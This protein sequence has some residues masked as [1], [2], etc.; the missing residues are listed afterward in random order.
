MNKRACALLVAVLLVLIAA[1]V[2]VERLLSA[3]ITGERQAANER[4]LLDLLAPGSYDNHPL[5]SPIVLPDSEKLGLPAP[6]SAYLATRNGVASA[7]LLPARG[8]GYEGSIE[9]LLAISPAGQLLAVKVLSEHETPGLGDLSSAAKSPWLRG[10]FGHSLSDTDWRMKADGGQFDQ[11]AGATVTSRA[12]SQAV[13]QGLRYF[14]EHRAVLLPP[15][16]P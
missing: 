14:D 6:A 13:Q 9:L 16:G 8:N 10:F 5:A 12:V 3:Q 4:A 15:V 1:V 2:G 11:M 7:V